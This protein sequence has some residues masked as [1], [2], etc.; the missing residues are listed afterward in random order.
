MEEEQELNEIE[1]KLTDTEDIDSSWEFKHLVFVIIVIAVLGYMYLQSRKRK[2]NETVEAATGTP[3]PVEPDSLRR[4]RLEKFGSTTVAPPSPVPSENAEDHTEVQ[5]SQGNSSRNLVRRPV[6]NGNG[7]TKKDVEKRTDFLNNLEKQTKERTPPATPESIPAKQV[8]EETP[9]KVIPAIFRTP[10]YQ[11]HRTLCKIFKV[12]VNSSEV[13]EGFALLESLAQELRSLPNKDESGVLLIRDADIDTLLIERITSMSSL[14]TLQ[15]L[16]QSFGNAAEELRRNKDSKEVMEH[17]MRSIISQAGLVAQGAPLELLSILE[18]EIPKLFL[19][20]LCIQWSEDLPSI[21]TPIYA[22]IF[23][24]VQKSTLMDSVSLV[25]IYKIMARLTAQPPLAKLLVKVPNWVVQTTNGRELQRNTYLGPFFQFS[26]VFDSPS[27]TDTYFPTNELTV[28]RVEESN[29]SLRMQIK[30]LQTVL[31]EIITNLLHADGKVENKVVRD[32]LLNWF[33]SA[34]NANQARSKMHYNMLQVS[35]DGFI[36]NLCSELLKLC[37]PFTSNTEKMNIIDVG[38]CLVNP[39]WINFANETR[40]GM[41]SEEV[42]NYMK[43]NK[44]SEKKQFNFVTEAFFLTH[45]ALHIGIVS[46][47]HRY[48]DFSREFSQMQQRKN[49]LTQ[50]RHMWSQ[51]P[52]A[53]FIEGFLKKL[54]DDMNKMKQF[55]LSLDAQVFESSFVKDAMEFY[56][57]SGRF[58]EKIADPEGKGLPLN[59][60]VPQ[61]FALLPEYFAQDVAE[62]LLFVIRIEPKAVDFSLLSLVNFFITFMG[63]VDYVK[64]PYV[65]AKLAEVLFEMFPHEEA[66]NPQLTRFSY[67]FESN[68]LAKK[69]LIPALFMLYVDIENTG[70]GGQFYEKFFVRR[71]IAVLLRYLRGI[72]DY[73]EAIK[74]MTKD[75]QLFIK[76]I[77]M[78]MNDNTYLLDEVLQKLPEIKEIETLRENPEAW[79][80][81]DENSR[82]DKEQALAAD[83]RTVT[84][85]MKLANEIILLFHFLSEHAIEP[86]LAPEMTERVAQMLNYFIQQLAG[87]KSLNLKVRDPQRFHFDPKFLLQKIVEIYVL[88]GEQKL[89]VESVV[90][91]I[92]SFKPEVFKKVVNILSRGNLLP[93]SSIKKFESFIS[94]A[95]STTVDGDED[96]LDI[97]ED[98]IPS[99]FMDPIMSHLMKDPVKLPS[100]GNVVDRSTIARIL[101][102]D[103]KDPFNRKPLTMEMIV[104]DLE[105]KAKI[106]EFKESKRKLKRKQ[107]P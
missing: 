95:E 35:S 77:N 76:F 66:N 26:S 94:K 56:G 82:Q 4:K 3:Q 1:S 52:R 96:D 49:E 102:T 65:R 7:N 31:H 57:F 33:A 44:I 71:H 11:L 69:H 99:E 9:K 51:T 5:P 28:Q 21:F 73:H 106:E 81:L 30:M 17:C 19:E 15:Y 92:R 27:H 40:F 20:Q 60:K 85:Y 103:G 86:F 37:S 72:P 100:S 43:S 64:N 25:K 78:V 68:P 45:Y 59:P 93:E 34:L 29:S 8:V 24:Q 62:Y 61:E 10:E 107:E 80:A 67:I 47:I 39:R 16:V 13:A 83:T 42:N 55:K 48:E 23:K 2:R 18:S 14:E 74:N 22:E 98:D 36:M 50:T 58:L 70:R 101:L 104:P 91:D 41:T 46:I 97:D 84:T 63:S 87:T 79:A 6:T 90:R 89:F 88:F 38:Y 105:L 54:E 32:A 12:T 75:T 53:M